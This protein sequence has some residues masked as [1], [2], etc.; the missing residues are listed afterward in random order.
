MRE[1]S[2]K[3]KTAKGLFW[4]GMSNVLQQALNLVFGVFLAR[5]LTSDDYG[6]VG[7]LT[8][9]SLIAAAIQESGFTAALANKKKVSHADYNAVF[10]FSVL[11][12]GVLYATLF[13]CAPL[14]SRFY[15]IPELTPLGRFVFLSFVF[16][17]FG[18]AQNAYMFRS[19]MVK[20]KTLSNNIALFLS[21]VVGVFLAWRGFAYWGIASQTLVYTFANTLCYWCF[22]PWR[23]SFAIDF[24][25]LKGMIGFSS[26]LLLSSVFI[27]INNNIV[28]VVLGKFYGQSDVG[29][30]SQANKWSYLGHSVVTGMVAGVSQPML[31]SVADEADR[32][33]RAFR[34]I[35]R[36]TA[37]V[38]FPVMFGIAL[39]APELI[40]IAITDKWLPSAALLRIIAIGAAF[41]PI[42]QLYSSLIISKGKSNVNLFNIVGMGVVTVCAMIA[43]HSYGMTA[44]VVAYVTIQVLWT[45]AWQGFAWREIG[46]PIWTSLKDIAPYIAISGAVMIATG[47]I[48]SGIE[49]IG[50]RFACE[51]FVAAALYIGIMWLSRAATFRES[52]DFIRHKI[53]RK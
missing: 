41:I 53:I 40:T 22:S 45:L 12:S 13:F 36:F 31:A 5:L 50:A 24:S 33:C 46:L 29:Y 18:V 27:H 15:G 39:V 43:M 25:P 37:F 26:K 9:F 38:S 17:S 10:W 16:S 32:Q 28:N 34:K 6:M 42:S 49:S 51:I 23:P 30:F 4:G 48:A 14:I 3:E 47:Y 20:Q 19:M 35:L 2:L 1:E 21:G 44:M 52:L 11:M 8:I 7:M